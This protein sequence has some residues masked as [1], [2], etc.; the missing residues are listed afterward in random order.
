[1]IKAM[2]HGNKSSLKKLGDAQL[3][4]LPNLIDQQVEARI[5]RLKRD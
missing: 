3:D 1:V 4:T 5:L 2:R